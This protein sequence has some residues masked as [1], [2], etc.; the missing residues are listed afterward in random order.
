VSHV[1][2]SYILA[3]A[4]LQAYVT[5]LIFSSGKGLYTYCAMSAVKLARI[6]KETKEKLVD[7]AAQRT[8]IT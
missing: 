4:T 7:D 2:C 3:P 1:T 8:K 6:R 5:G